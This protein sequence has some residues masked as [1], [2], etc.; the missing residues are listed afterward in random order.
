LEVKVL[1]SGPK[2]AIALET[3]LLPARRQFLKVNFFAL[4]FALEPLQTLRLRKFGK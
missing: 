3:I 2:T 1:S 4:A